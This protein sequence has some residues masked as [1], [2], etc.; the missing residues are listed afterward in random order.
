MSTQLI[1]VGGQV[2]IDNGGRNFGYFDRSQ[3]QAIY[4]ALSNTVS[5]TCEAAGSINTAAVNG[6]GVL[7]IETVTGG[8]VDITSQALWD[9]N[10]AL[11]FPNEGGGSIINAGVYLPNVVSF[12]GNI[13]A[14][15]TKN[16]F[17]QRIGNIV[18]LSFAIDV[19]IDV[20]PPTTFGLITLDIPVNST[21]P[22]LINAIG[23]GNSET[24]YS[25]C[26]IYSDDTTPNQI[27]MAIPE[28]LV[29]STARYFV[30][31]S[32]EIL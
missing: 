13:N 3:F 9:T 4:N 14:A 26:Y 1:Q 18:F 32:Y 2:R 23:N 21:F 5:M 19:T 10:F 16:G 6:G 8:V 24:N 11:L 15:T 12:N 27:I 30:T 25:Q 7:S 22:G 17:Y 28:I 29:A 31:L 20:A